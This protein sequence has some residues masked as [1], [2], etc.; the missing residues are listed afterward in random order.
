MSGIKYVL[1]TNVVIGF[2]AGVDWAVSFVKDAAFKDAE[3]FI[4]AITRMELLGFPGI[5][6]DE[7][8]RINQFLSIVTKIDLTPQIEDT[9]IGIRRISRLKLPDAIVTASAIC[10]D[11]TLV[12]ADTDFKGVEKLQLLNPSV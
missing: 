10:E 11:A 6:P 8:S 3:L 7:E 5:T 9:A 12:S 1:D 2:L 4:S